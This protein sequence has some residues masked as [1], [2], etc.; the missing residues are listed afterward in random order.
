MAF[1]KVFLDSSVLIGLV[2]RHAGERELCQAAR[3]PR[4]QGVCSRYVLFE[5]AR[6]FLRS[7]IA[8]YNYSLEFSSFAELHRAAHAG[9]QRFRPYAMHTWLGAF[10]DYF[11]VLEVEDGVS[12]ESLKL[13]EFRA[14]LRGWIRRGWRQMAT[15]VAWVNPV[16][17]REDLPPPVTR[18]D[19]RIDQRLPTEECGQPAACRLQAFIQLRR[20][21]VEAVRDGLVALPDSRIDKETSDRIAA[22]R[23]LLA[24]PS[25]TPFVGR[26]CH[27]SGDALI[28]LESPPGYVIA[29]KN[30]KHFQPLGE[31]LGKPVRLVPTAPVP[32]Q[33]TKSD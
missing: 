7:L 28:C 26:Q 8:L 16:G 15:V 31:I 17:C 23:H 20:P 14:K 33:V 21:Q 9:Q 29:T 4:G 25:G 18:G 6:G 27:R 19:E 24:T 11:A 5:V 1:D 30:G 13:E 32:R 2:F 10:D 3:G 22:L 12:S